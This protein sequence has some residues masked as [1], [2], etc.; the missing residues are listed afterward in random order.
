[1]DTQIEQTK[2]NS[3]AYDCM[4][5]LSKTKPG[6]FIEY[7]NEGKFRHAVLESLDPV[8]QD[9]ERDKILSDSQIS[10]DAF[11]KYWNTKYCS[12][13]IEI[14]IRYLIPFNKRSN[15]EIQYRI[16]RRTFNDESGWQYLS[17]VVIILTTDEKGTGA[18]HYHVI[19]YGDDDDNCFPKLLKD[20]KTKDT[21][22]LI[23]LF[24][25]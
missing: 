23:S 2:N 3:C 22:E 15:S 16:E 18:G 4:K 24:N 25:R 1:M 6:L 9:S 21:H 8:F 11:E 12:L 10:F 14:I 7:P 13:K 17:G 19:K 20:V 5:F